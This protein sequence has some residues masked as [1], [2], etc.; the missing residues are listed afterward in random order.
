MAETRAPLESPGIPGWLQ[1]TPFTLVFL[2]FFVLPLCFV[3]T[4]SFWD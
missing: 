2:L 4:V 1:A 3:I